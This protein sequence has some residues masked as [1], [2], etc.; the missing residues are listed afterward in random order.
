M[1]KKMIIERDDNP[2]IFGELITD[3]TPVNLE[4][5]KG[6]THYCNL[7]VRVD[8]KRYPEEKFKPY[9][10]DWLSDTVIWSDYDGIDLEPN[11]LYRAKEEKITKTEWRMV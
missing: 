4:H 8:E 1:T 2:D 7:L 6:S 10:G 11:K 9:Y 3:Y 5:R